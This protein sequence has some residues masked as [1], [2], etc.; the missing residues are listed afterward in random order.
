MAN[1]ARWRVVPIVV[2]VTVSVDLTLMAPGSVVV[3]VDGT[4]LIVVFYWSITAVMVVTM[5]KVINN[6]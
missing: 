1:T 5:T 4:G 3:R 2:R 6:S